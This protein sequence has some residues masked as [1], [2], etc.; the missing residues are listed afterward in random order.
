MSMGSSY[1]GGRCAVV[2]KSERFSMSVVIDARWKSD[3]CICTLRLK[4]GRRSTEASMVS[5]CI[6]RGGWS[7]NIPFKKCNTIYNEESAQYIK[8]KI[9]KTMYYY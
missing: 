4:T 6:V 7:L 9:K 1:R 2:R 8:V 3:P 5:A